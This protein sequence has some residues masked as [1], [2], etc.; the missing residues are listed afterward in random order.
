M[1]EIGRVLVWIIHEQERESPGTLQAMAYTERR[2]ACQEWEGRELCAH[3]C[4]TGRVTL[5]RL[6]GRQ[7][8]YDDMERVGGATNEGCS[9]AVNIC[10]VTITAWWKDCPPVKNSRVSSKSSVRVRAGWRRVMAVSL[11]SWAGPGALF[12]PYVSMSGQ[13][14]SRKWYNVQPSFIDYE[15]YFP[16]LEL[17]PPPPS[18]GSGQWVRA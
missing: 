17:T 12:V 8:R 14:N 7:V 15:S 11:D 2:R 9:N 18:N 4:M 16:S 10:A 3:A 13:K 1:H 6:N 5:A